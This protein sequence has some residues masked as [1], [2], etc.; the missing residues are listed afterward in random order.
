MKRISILKR[1]EREREGERESKKKI[2]K[3][4]FF[5]RRARDEWHDNAAEKE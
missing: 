4:F 5:L 3:E 1:R 2:M